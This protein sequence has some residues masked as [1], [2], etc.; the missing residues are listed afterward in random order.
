MELASGG[1]RC[2]RTASRN[3]RGEFVASALIGL[4]T[5]LAEGFIGGVLHQHNHAV[6]GAVVFLLLATETAI[7]VLLSRFASRPVVQAG[8]GLPAALALIVAAL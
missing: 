2:S 3:S 8:L 4:V 7:Q 5:S 6:Q 1:L